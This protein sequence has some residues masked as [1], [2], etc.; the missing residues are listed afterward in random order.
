MVVTGGQAYLEWKYPV[1]DATRKRDRIPSCPYVWPNGQG[2]SSKFLGGVE[3][4]IAW[5]SQYGETYRIWSGMK[6]EIVLTQPQQ[7]CAVF[8]DSDK[9]F[10]APANNSGFYMSRLLGQC[11]GLISGSEWRAVRAVAEIPFGHG[12]VALQFDNF[13]RHVS[14]HFAALHDFKGIGDSHL[15]KGLLH[16]VDDLAMLPF[17]IVADMFYGQLSPELRMLLEGMVPLRIKI[18]NSHVI[19]GGL[20]RF[21]WSRCLPTAAN[22][23]LKRFKREWKAFNRRVLERAQQ[24]KGTPP[25]IVDMYG[26]VASRKIS[27]EQLLQ[28]LDE[29]LFAN[30]DVTISGLSWI[31]V[32]LAA[33]KDVQRRLRTEIEA[34]TSLGADTFRR[35]LLNGSSTYL[36]CCVLESSRLRPLAAFSV[37]QA[38]PTPRRI[39]VTS[40]PGF[41]VPAGTSFVV[42]TYALNVRNKAWAPD[43]EGFRPGRFMD[44]E[45]KNT[46]DRRYLLW[47]FG[48]GPRQCMGRH[49]ADLIIRMTVA[50]LLRNYDLDLLSADDHPGEVHWAGSKSS[51][52]THPD[53]KL[54]CTRLCSKSS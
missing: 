30:L 32:F 52:I 12:A 28:T 4:S 43:N 17:R 25:P 26:A 40:G 38:A 37:P 33:D 39:D 14:G 41:V 5:G 22:A 35:Y 49:A 2:D 10:K 20:H 1:L 44:S 34:Q 42:D 45:A 11:V 21:A 8:K 24:E 7:L 50:Y 27:E 6:P 3:N 53:F 9:H 51:W 15:N 36:A 31:T 48:F 16:P 23:E 18:F 19:G 46:V 47:R 54:K 13:Q 29:S